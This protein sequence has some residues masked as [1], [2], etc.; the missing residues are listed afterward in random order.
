M[1]SSFHSVLQAQH[2]VQLPTEEFALST[3]ITAC[4]GNIKSYLSGNRT[5]ELGRQ[6]PTQM[7]IHQ[8]AWG[9][10]DAQYSI[11]LPTKKEQCCKKQS[12][13]VFYTS[14]ED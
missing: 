10:K 13:E 8:P 7:R 1:D 11:T 2:F 12:L 3:E 5:G 14:Q 4:M 9:V 6:E